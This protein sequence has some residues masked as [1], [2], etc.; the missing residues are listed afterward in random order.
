MYR[1]LPNRH[2][3]PSTLFLHA[4]VEHLCEVIADLVPLVCCKMPSFKINNVVANASV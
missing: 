1:S 4:Q 3:Q 2:E